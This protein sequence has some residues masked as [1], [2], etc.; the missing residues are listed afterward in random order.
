MKI[1]VTV[2]TQK[3]FEIAIQARNIAVCVGGSF[4][5][6][7]NGTEAPEIIVTGSAE[8]F[9]VAWGSSQPRVEAWG[10]SQPRVEARES[11]QPRVVAR[12]SSQ[13]RVV[14]WGYVQLSIFGAVIVSASELVAVLIHGLKATVK[15]GRQTKVVIKTSKEWCDYYGVK[16]EKGIA[17]LYKALNEDFTAPQGMSYKPGTVPVAPDW[18]GGKQECGG[19][20]HFSPTPGMARAFHPGALKYVGCPVAL[21]DI[22]VHPDGQNPEKVKAKKCVGPVWECNE[23]G[24]KIGK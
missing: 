13:P 7:T 14:A 2:K 1:E 17:I 15:G 11:S 23:D 10:S 24:E 21:K 22:V 19:G 8:I 18:D 3:E 4:Q 9:V 12:E 5:L 6:T 16:V 20:L